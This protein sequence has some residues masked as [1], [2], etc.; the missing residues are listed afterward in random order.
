M[1]IAGSSGRDFSLRVLPRRASGRL[2]CP[3]RRTAD[4][5][6]LAIAVGIQVAGAGVSFQGWEIADC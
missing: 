2:G 4:S 3:D 5:S 6:Q 1:N